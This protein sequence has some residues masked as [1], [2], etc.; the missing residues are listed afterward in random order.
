M[1]SSAERKKCKVEKFQQVA[2]LD[3]FKSVTVNLKWQFIYFANNQIYQTIAPD[4]Q[5]LDS[6]LPQGKIFLRKHFLILGSGYGSVGRAVASYTRCLRFESSLGL[7]NIYFLSTEK[8]RINYK[9]GPYKNFFVLKDL[10]LILKEQLY[11][12]IYFLRSKIH[13]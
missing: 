10:R 8:S 7:F 12:K 2:I 13:N 5:Y 9:N 3:L 4:V 1:V 6:Y 11:L